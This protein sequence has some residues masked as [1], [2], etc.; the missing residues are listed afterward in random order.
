M[1]N[2]GIPEQ[3]ALLRAEIRRR[4]KAFSKEDLAGY[5]KAV[6]RSIEEDPAFI[7]AQ[8]V[9]LYYSLPDEVQTQTLIEKWHQKKT[10]LLPVVDGEELRLKHYKG[11]QALTP[12][13]WN[14]LEPSGAVFQDLNKI[15]LIILPA[16]AYDKEGHRLGRGKGFYDRLMHKLH[17]PSIGICFP[18]QLLNHIPCDDWDC[19]VDRVIS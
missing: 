11:D 15:D 10:I 16:M 8:T 5:S 3:K 4:K 6:C 1:G 2:L 9:L 12:N 7:Q 14:I 17:C 18:F 19:Q 13:Q